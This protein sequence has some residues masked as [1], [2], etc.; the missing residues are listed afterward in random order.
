MKKQL[1]VLAESD[2]TVC[3]RKLQCSDINGTIGPTKI[4]I[5]TQIGNYLLEADLKI[6][7]IHEECQSV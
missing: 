5:V 2:S 7:K 1:K 6:T 4:S 3:N